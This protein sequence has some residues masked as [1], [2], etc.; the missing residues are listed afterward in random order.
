[1]FSDVV[2]LVG[3]MVTI[4]LLSTMAAVRF[5]YQGRWTGVREQWQLF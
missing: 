5:W 1:M 4:Q 3:F 2:A